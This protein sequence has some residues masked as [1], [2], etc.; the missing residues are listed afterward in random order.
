MTYVTS[1]GETRNTVCQSARSALPARVSAAIALAFLS[2]IG[3]AACMGKS[4]EGS[5]AGVEGGAVPSPI[6]PPPPARQCARTCTAPADCTEPGAPAIFDAGHFACTNDRCQFT[7]CKTDS[8]CTFDDDRD[9][10]CEAPPGATQKDCILTCTTA[11]DCPM[12][13]AP[14][15]Y[16]AAHFAC[17]N[18]RCQYTGCKT[19]SECADVNGPRSVCD[20]VPGTPFKACAASCNRPAD[21]TRPD[22]PAAFDSSHFACLANRCQ[23]TGCKSDTECTSENGADLICE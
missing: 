3:A 22:A 5:R 19:D 20:A 23:Y 12:Q 21:C 13:G 4:A 16:D 18:G 2:T 1:T 14:G 9:W 6:T 8:E 10:V 15:L 7:G 17:T 11:A